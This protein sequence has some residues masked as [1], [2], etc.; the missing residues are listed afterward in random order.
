MKRC[1]VSITQ[2]KLNIVL[3]LNFNCNSNSQSELFALILHEC[4]DAHMTGR[5]KSCEINGLLSTAANQSKGCKSR[6]DVELNKWVYL[7]SNYHLVNYSQ[8]M[9]YWCQISHYYYLVVLANKLTLAAGGAWSV[10]SVLLSI[11]GILA[12]S[13]VKALAHLWCIYF[14]LI[15]YPLLCFS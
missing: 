13:W 15:F 1:S 5:H 14:S 3:V 6:C 4:L 10:F 11:F 8:L 9:C 2:R 7:F 12:L